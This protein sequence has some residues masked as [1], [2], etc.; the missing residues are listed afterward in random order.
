M[1]TVLQA[2]RAFWGRGVG[3]HVVAALAARALR[4]AGVSRVCAPVHADNPRSMRVLQKNGFEREGLLRRSVLKAG[5][6]ID[7]V[8]W[9][10]YAD[11]RGS[12]APA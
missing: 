12:A 3:T 2:G 7:I 5:R 1:Y 11:E 6:P 9:A 4:L 10:R 8:L